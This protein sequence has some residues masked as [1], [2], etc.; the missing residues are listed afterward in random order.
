MISHQHRCIFIHIPKCA[1]TSIEASLGHSTGYNGRVSQDHRSIRMIQPLGVRE[2]L[3]GMPALET[4]I[5]RLKHRFH[6]RQNP[7]N[8]HTVTRKQYHE[9]FKCTIVRNPWARVHSAWRNVVRDEQHYNRLGLSPDTS[10]YEFVSQTRGV[11]MLKPQTDWLLD[12][13]GNL[14]VDYVGR[15]EE[16]EKSFEHICKRLNLP[17]AKLPHEIKGQEQDFRESYDERTRQLV[18][19]FFAVEIDLFEYSFHAESD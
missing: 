10:L 9:Y 14:A 17:V 16:L 19:D 11:G 13:R 15:F 7:R 12:L 1:G 4:M 5:R 3:T 6:K 18:A 2:I 8:H